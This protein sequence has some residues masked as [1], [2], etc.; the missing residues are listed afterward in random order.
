LAKPVATSVHLSCAV[1][2]CSGW[3]RLSTTIGKTE[4]LAHAAYKIPSGKTATVSLS[5]T[6]TG[7]AVLA[8]VARKPHKERLFATVKGGKRAKRTL[9]VS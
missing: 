4:L 7:R 9:L 6:S 1:A 3:V 5:V 8:Q 2:S